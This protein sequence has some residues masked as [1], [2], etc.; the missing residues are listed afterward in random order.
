MTLLF[1]L[2]QCNGT[3]DRLAHHAVRSCRGNRGMMPIMFFML[4]AALA[5]MGPGN[6]ATAALMA[7][8]A[9]ATA[10]R[11]GIPLFLMAIMV[12]NGANAGS[13]SPFAPTG[14]IVSGLMSRI[15]MPGHE[16]QTYLY[17]LLAH[18]LVAFGGY[19]LFGGWKLFRRH[20]PVPCA[21]TDVPIA[22]DAPMETQHWMTLGVIALLLVERDRPRRQRRHGGIR[23]RGDPGA[24]RLRR[25]S[26][27]DQADAVA[28]DRHGVRRHGAD[29]R[30]SKRPKA[31]T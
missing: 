3:L 8:M 16:W 15:E 30:V 10:G 20:E 23:R 28:R 31:S 13:L 14:I 29:C 21:D 27:G 7:P 25:R 4:A 1:S 18:A 6:I 12:G 2:A 26:R 24:V 9:M 11:V 19:F 22:G 5:S 17:N